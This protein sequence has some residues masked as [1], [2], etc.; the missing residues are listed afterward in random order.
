VAL[1]IGDDRAL[2]R[3]EVRP[4]PPARVAR[5]ALVL[6]AI[7]ARADMERT[8]QAPATAA[9]RDR[10]LDWLNRA[11]LADEAEPQEWSLLSAALGS[12]PDGQAV[13]A[14]WK[15]EAAAVLT[16]A[17]GRADLPSHD[18]A[19]TPMQVVGALQFMSVEGTQR[20]ISAATLRGE[21]EIYHMY[22]RLWQIHWRL[23]ENRLTAGQVDLRE[24]EKRHDWWG[25]LDIPKDALSRDGDLSVGG[26]PLSKAD[27]R[28]VAWCNSIAME[29]HRGANWLIGTERIY[30]AIS[31]DT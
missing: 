22:N 12:W 4:P 21:V 13:D 15:V 18:V 31:T 14:S 30:S 5:R 7:S 24:M 19:A 1:M 8:Q 28:E 3:E 2:W 23:T 16:W 11:G 6:G 26:R 17:L 25:Q 27:P 29:R 9:F 20:V 10:L